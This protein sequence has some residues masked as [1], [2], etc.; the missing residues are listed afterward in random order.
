MAPRNQKRKANYACKSL[1]SFASRQPQENDT[2]SVVIRAQQKK[3]FLQPYVDGLVN[4]KLQ[5]NKKLTINSYISNVNTL[6]GVDVD[7]VS[8]DSL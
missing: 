1:Q 4:Q 8:L 5:Q 2:N 7:W 6:K 3:A